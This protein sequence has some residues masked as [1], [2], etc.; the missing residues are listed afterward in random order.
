MCDYSL[1]AIQNRLA[2]EGDRLVAHKFRTGTTGLVGECDFKGWRA[3][4][5]QRWWDKIK[6]CLSADLGPC[7]VVCIPPG[8]QLRI[9]QLPTA[10]QQQFD[11]KPYEEATFTQLSADVNRHRDGLLFRNGKKML[12]QL[13]PE[14][15]TVTV[16]RLSSDE[17]RVGPEGVELLQPMLR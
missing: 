6:D 8:A 10:L 4:R 14:G 17:D 16:L 3:G 1:M 9:E 15:Q 7:P 13:L 2:V 12:L 5:P 11:L